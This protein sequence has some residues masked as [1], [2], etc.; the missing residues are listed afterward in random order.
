MSQEPDLPKIAGR[1]KPDWEQQNQIIWVDSKDV[2]Q[3]ISKSFRDFTWERDIQ[4]Q[5]G[6]VYL[7]EDA[8]IDL[9]VHLRSNTE[10]EQGG[11]LFGNAYQDPS[12]QIIYVE[13]TAAVAAPATIGTSVSLD[14]TPDSWVGIMNYARAKHPQEN[15]VGWYH[16]HPNIGVF[17]SGTDMNTQ[18]AFFH[19]P[20]CL[21]I[22]Y[23]PLR[24][25]IGFFL[26]AEAV[27]VDAPII[28]RQKNYDPE[29]T[30]N[31]ID[32]KN[33]PTD[34]HNA[35][36]NTNNPIRRSIRF[37]VIEDALIPIFAGLA[38]LF[39]LIGMSLFKILPANNTPSAPSLNS[40]ATV[41]SAFNAEIK[42]MPASVFSYLKKE[43]NVLQYPIV[44][45]GN[46]INLVGDITLL[47]ISQQLTGISE[48]IQLEV[49]DI[50]TKDVDFIKLLNTPEDSQKKQRIPLTS[51]NK[52]GGVLVPLFSSRVSSSKQKFTN[53]E[54]SKK[55][56][57]N[58]VYIP[59]YLIYK[60]SS[61]NRQEIKIPIQKILQND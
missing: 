58:T 51:L 42:R 32:N 31:K 34:T 13:I 54:Q 25:E 46:K 60:D 4:N 7:K 47:F 10:V 5:V 57:R 9:K 48:E 59:R 40:T 23:D 15:I 24:R 14:F 3:P 43:P 36:K 38:I 30:S 8:L 55:E 1:N 11:I 22:V 45:Q 56:V 21:S 26:G 27:L 16:S 12:S 50:T 29:L 18:R 6:R 49:E 52:K 20:W 44:E 37:P 39:V 2:Y 53:A 17:M 19:H 33:S 28:F 35:T 61:Q 41:S